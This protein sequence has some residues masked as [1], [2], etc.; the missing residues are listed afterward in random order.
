VGSSGLITVS[1]EEVILDFGAACVV[2]GLVT[3]SGVD[4][5]IK[6][7]NNVSFASGIT[8]TGD[9]FHSDGGGLKTEFA[10]IISISSA[11]EVFLLNISIDTKTGT[12]GNHA[13]AITGA[14]SDRIKLHGLLI[15]DSDSVGL[16]NSSSSAQDHLISGCMFLGSDSSGFNIRNTRNIIIGNSLSGS[17]GVGIN[18]SSANDNNIISANMIRDQGTGDAAINIDAG[19]EDCVVVGNRVDDLGTS[20]GINDAS[21]TSIVGAN[22]ETAF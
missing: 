14:D 17:G 2:D 3:W 10:D 16:N 9:R 12:T 15:N 5:T 21:G 7:R 6:G 19:A 22:N 1:A 18:T 8:I 13:L 4:G 20:D 11:S